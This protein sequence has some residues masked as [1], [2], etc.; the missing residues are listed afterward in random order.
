MNLPEW[1]HGD[2]AR[3]LAMMLVIRR[4]PR[5]RVLMTE[6]KLVELIT[7]DCALIKKDYPGFDFTLA[8]GTTPRKLIAQMVTSGVLYQRSVT[9]TRQEAELRPTVKIE[10]HKVDPQMK[11]RE[12]MASMPPE[13]RQFADEL[14]MSR[15]G[16][17]ER[18]AEQA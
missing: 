16:L 14:P 6:E 10:D 5:N 4:V 17:L 7:E 18:L 2:K 9:M 1:C 13:V 12:F 8:A 11:T 15:T 3:L